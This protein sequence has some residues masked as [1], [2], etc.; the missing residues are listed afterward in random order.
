MVQVIFTE[1]DLKQMATLGITAAEVRAQLEFFQ[2]GIPFQKLIRP[3]TVGDGIIKISNSDVSELLKKHKEGA[4]RGRFLKFVPASGAATRMFAQLAKCLNLYPHLS[5]AEITSAA[6][7]GREEAKEFLQFVKGIKNFAFYSELNSILAQ[8]GLDLEILL[9]QGEYRQLIEILLTEQ[10]L[11]YAQL[12]KALIKFHAYPD[13]NRTALEEHLVEAVG[14]IQDKNRV[15]R[16]HFTISPE[17]EKLF[18]QHL[19]TVRPEYEKKYQVGFQVDF[20]L[21]KTST[22]TIAVNLNNQPFRDKEGRLVFRPG[23]HGALIENLNAIKGDLIYIKNIDNVVPDRLKSETFL[24]KK[25]L[26]GFL[27]KIQEKVFGYLNELVNSQEEKL[28]QEA[29]EFAHD[30]L[31]LLPPPHNPLNSLKDKREFLLTK[32]NRPIRVGG[33]VKNQGEPGGGPFWVKGK[34]GSLSLQVVESAQVNMNSEKQRSIWNRATHFSPVDF[35]CAVRD[36]KGKPF[37]LKKYVDPNAVFISQKSK[38][39]ETLKALELPGLWNGGMADWITIFI[40]VPLIT[41]NPV[42]TINDLLRPEHQ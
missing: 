42:K 21:Q 17:Q 10:G 34:D 36:Y 28:I 12:P 26:G 11:N 41:F 15:C 19:S 18:L 16:L 23:G 5:H 38:D 27:I 29:F 14:Y 24:W 35:V 33:M 39:G 30:E 7:A 22:N 13:G 32:L 6:D 20:S 1:K 3:C 25:I 8:K 40:E 4:D 9:Q 31:F 2:Q 37:D